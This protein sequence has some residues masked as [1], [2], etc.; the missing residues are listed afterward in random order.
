MTPHITDTGNPLI[1]ACLAAPLLDENHVAVRRVE[2][3]FLATRVAHD[4]LSTLVDVKNS[5]LGLV[6]LGLIAADGISP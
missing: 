2:I 5:D 3:E 6:N 1:T 4:Q